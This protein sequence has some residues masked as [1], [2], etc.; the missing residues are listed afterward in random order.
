[1][2]GP[3]A[4]WL[5]WV[6]LAAASL[7]IFEEFVFPGRFMAWYRRARPSIS[8]S[9]T[10][11]YLIMVNVL[12]LILC[13]DVHALRGRPLGILLWLVV[14]GVLSANGVWHVVW[15]ARSRSYSPG[16][17]TGVVLYVPMAFYGLARFVGPGRIPLLNAALAVGAGASYQIWSD[18]LHRFRS[19]AATGGT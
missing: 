10:P 18:L 19:K 17:V 11:P 2:T 8:A 1:M 6:P 15:T 5:Y 13:Y 7:H 12:L 16:L 4:D 3:P 9:I 14:A